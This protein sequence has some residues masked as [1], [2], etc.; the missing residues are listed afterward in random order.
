[1][2]F[3]CVWRETPNSAQDDG[4]RLTGAN[5]GVLRCASEWQ[6]L[7]GIPMFDAV[8]L[9]RTWGTR[10]CCLDMWLGALAQVLEEDVADGG[11]GD[12]NGEILEREDVVQRDGE[13]LARAVSAVEFA[14]QEVGVEEEDDEGNLDHRPAKVS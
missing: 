6:S 7:R 3:D 9:R 12:G 10:I 1:M 2:S 4:G 5:A 8:V 13:G 11:G 14:H